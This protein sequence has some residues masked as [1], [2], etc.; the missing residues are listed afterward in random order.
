MKKIIAI[1]FIMLLFVTSVCARDIPTR[2]RV[3]CVKGLEYL[4][5]EKGK[6]IEWRKILE[7]GKPVRCEE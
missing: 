2:Y 6:D 5:I 4:L 7:D 1:M 3:V